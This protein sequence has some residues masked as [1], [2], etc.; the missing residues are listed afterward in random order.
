VPKEMNREN[1]RYNIKF[2]D[3]YSPRCNK[4]LNEYNRGH[5]KKVNENYNWSKM[6]LG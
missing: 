3:N 6:F 5:N 2:P 1:F 4:C